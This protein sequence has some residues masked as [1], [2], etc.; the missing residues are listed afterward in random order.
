MSIQH[1]RKIIKKEDVYD[2]RVFWRYR[3]K[4]TG[5]NERGRRISRYQSLWYYK[6]LRGKRILDAGFGCGDFFENRLDGTVVYGI[7]INIHAANYF[8]RKGFRVCNA[9]VVNIP[10]KDNAFDGIMCANVINLLFPYEVRNMFH[11]FQRVL[12]PGGRLLVISTIGEFVWRDPNGIRPYPVKAIKSLLI[13]TDFKFIESHIL[14][15]FPYM[16]L[17]ATIYP[18]LILPL[19][20][21][22]GL[23]KKAYQVILA[24]AT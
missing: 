6:M 24:E 15:H 21:M 4:F 18:Q 12:V 14:C 9:S 3:E 11:E 16:G 8:A 5:L 13:D 23:F 10:F 7:D 22:M 17:I 1:S 20:K 2:G 19:Q